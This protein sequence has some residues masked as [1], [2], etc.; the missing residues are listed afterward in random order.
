MVRL[1]G[2]EL[3]PTAI[4][5]VARADS[6]LPIDRES[7]VEHRLDWR[8][9]DL[10]QPR[11]R[12]VFEVQT[13]FERAVREFAY[14]RGCTELHTPKL[15]GTAS[16]SGAEVFRVSYF[17][18]TAYLAQSP[19]F[20]KQLAIAGGVDRVFEI[21]PVFRAE[22]SFTARHATEFTG[23]DVEIAW[24]DGHAPG[25]TQ[26]L[27]G[28]FPVRNPAAR[29]LRRRTEPDS[30]GAPRSGQR[31]RVHLPVP[32][33]APPAPL[34]PGG[35]TCLPPRDR[36]GGRWSTVD[37]V[38]VSERRSPGRTRPFPAVRGRP[39]HP[40][41]GRPEDSRRRRSSASSRCSATRRGG[42]IDSRGAVGVK[43]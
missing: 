23:I 19:Q 10:R 2:L 36:P 5:V 38:R 15:M 32:R 6:P 33:P 26:V 3:V 14:A 12:A 37:S 22:P 28:L 41:C 40:G 31:P 8:F 24:I 17:D 20:Y 42:T 30:H 16:E 34:N 11:R 7:G 9:L 39:G 29:R 1:G 27:S 21:G 13:T 43:S 18:T 35:L 4:E 25:S